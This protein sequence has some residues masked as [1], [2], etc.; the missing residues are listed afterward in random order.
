M[1]LM[2]DL[3]MKTANID[4]VQLLVMKTLRELQPDSSPRR[5]PLVAP[6]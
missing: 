6:E 5:P 2:S 3:H 4:T 1:E